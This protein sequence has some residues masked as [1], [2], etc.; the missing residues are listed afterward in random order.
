MIKNV[1]TNLLMI[2]NIYYYFYNA[3]LYRNLEKK[4]C[5]GSST[6]L[7]KFRLEAQSSVFLGDIEFLL[8]FD[9][10]ITE[11]SFN[12]EGVHLF[13]KNTRL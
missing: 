10:K 3:V 2:S 7:E 1:Y 8:P 4:N 6:T 5:Y 12:F 11:I 9:L 13:K